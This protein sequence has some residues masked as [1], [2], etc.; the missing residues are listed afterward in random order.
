MAAKKLQL[1][2]SNIKHKILY[3]MKR[4]I[5]T[6]FAV[7]VYTCI[8]ASVNVY[9]PV[10]VSPADSAQNQDVNVQ[11]NWSPVAGAFSYNILIDTDSLFSN[12]VLM[13]A[14]LTAKEADQ[15]HFN[16][17]Y[18]WKVQ[19]VG[20]NA[21]DTSN[22]SLVRCF[23]TV[24][25]VSLLLPAD[26]AINQ[27]PKV[28]LRWKNLNGV[29]FFDMICDT[30]PDF[31]SPLLIMK[32]FDVSMHPPIAMMQGQTI[33][34]YYFED[35]VQHLLFNT[36]YYWSVRARHDY[37]TSDYASPRMLTVL[38]TLVLTSPADSAVSMAPNHDL[39]WN[40]ITGTLKYQIEIDTVDTFD[41]MM[42]SSFYSYTNTTKPDTL[43]FN[44]T[45]FWR[46]RALHM[47]DTSMFSATFSFTTIDKPV[48]TTPANNAL[49]VGVNPLLKWQHIDGVQSFEVEIANDAAFTSPVI[50]IVDG[51]KDEVTIMPYTLNVNQTYYWRMLAWH[52][53][54]TSDWS[55][56]F[57]FTTGNTGIDDE[58]ANTGFTVYPNPARS[59]VNVDIVSGFNTTAN[60]T[61]IDITGK[62][63]FAS[64]I[65]LNKGRNVKNINL[66]GLNEGIYFVQVRNNEININRKLIINN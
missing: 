3:R 54:D 46:V 28:N 17:M 15:L 58:I 26:S 31:N 13:T 23:T 43:N 2:L 27:M 44:Q 4:L 20:M 18:Y 29:K 39:T 38:D 35:F 37:D 16:T 10:L 61:V 25:V 64:L 65:T 7:I 60:L 45:Y 47:L 56:T 59:S 34:Y 33:L 53:R 22:W 24:E 1:S 48:P 52:S 66:N 30:T 62:E 49:M 14:S 40:E 12:P 57:Q 19:A 42:F 11:L 32:S 51:S 6:V 5:T 8:Y 63:V 9:A 55:N 21:N 41:S 36:T 50:F